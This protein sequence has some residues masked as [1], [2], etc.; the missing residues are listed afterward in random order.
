MGPFPKIIVRYTYFI[1]ISWIISGLGQGSQNESLVGF[2]ERIGCFS[3]Q[4]NS[5]IPDSLKKCH[6]LDAWYLAYFYKSYRSTYDPFESVDMV[7]TMPPELKEWFEGKNRKIIKIWLV[8]FC[9]NISIKENKKFVS[10]NQ[11]VNG[12]LMANCI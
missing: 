3:E 4:A 12:T 1:I 6:V 10:D 5:A 8:S 11:Y 7:T 2:M 9:P